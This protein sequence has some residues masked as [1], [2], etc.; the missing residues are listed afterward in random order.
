MI[1]YPALLVGSE[2]LPNRTGGLNRYF[3]GLS[4]ALGDAGIGAIGLVTFLRPGQSGPIPIKPFAREGAGMLERIAGARSAALAAIEDGIS[5]ANPHF[6]L[7]AWPWVRHVPHNVPLVVNFQGPWADEM[8]AECR[9]V[10]CRFKSAAARAIER[11]VY[12]RADRC[13]TLSN[14]FR[15]VLAVRF[16]VPRSRIAVVPGGVTLEPFLAAPSQSEARLKLGWPAEAKI[17]FCVRRLTR[18]MG[19]DL[20]IQATSDLRREVPDLLV[21][22]AGTGHAEAELKAQAASAGLEDIVR[23]IGFLP[24]KQLPIAYAAADLTVVP[25]VALEGF[26]LILVESLASG[27]PAIATPVGGM[28]EVLSGFPD[29]VTEAA[30]VEALAAKLRYALSGNVALPSPSE[31]RAY[32]ARFGWQRVLPALLA[33]WRDVGA[34]IPFDPMSHIG[35]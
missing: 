16:G 18:R 9:S 8:L 27:T 30:T 33:V 2:W 21:I 29:L 34:E 31:C 19:V 28:P 26:G 32:A 13:I 20:L 5:V 12:T 23:F 22:I 35:P 10:R 6:A 17:A 7:Y 3:W 14:A 11:S 4:N 25:S 1:N 24:D 15:E